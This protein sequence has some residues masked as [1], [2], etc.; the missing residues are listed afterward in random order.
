MHLGDNSLMMRG[1]DIVCPGKDIQEVSSMAARTWLTVSCHFV[2]R[3]TYPPHPLTPHYLYKFKLNRSNRAQST[4]PPHY[5]TV[6]SNAVSSGEGMM[7]K[8]K[9]KE[10]HVVKEVEVEDEDYGL[11]FFKG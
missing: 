1:V 8:N 3:R 7:T 10:V 9:G 6:V 11:C 5:T 4:T 2:H